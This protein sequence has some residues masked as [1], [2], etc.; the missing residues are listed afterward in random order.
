MG[1]LA[2]MS[3]PTTNTKRRTVHCSKHAFAPIASFRPKNA[4]A[5]SAA[6]PAQ[7]HQSNLGRAGLASES[8]FTGDDPVN[9]IDP[10]GLDCGL[11]SCACSAYDSAAGGVKTAAKDTGHAINAALPAIHTIANSVAIAASLCAVIT[12]ETVVGGVTC[13]A[14]ASVAGGVTAVTGGVLYLEGRESGVNAAFDLAGG[15]LGGTSSLYEAVADS[16]RALQESAELGSA[17][18]LAALRAS[19]WGAFAT[20]LSGI[21]RGLSA[22]AFGLGLGA[23]FGVNC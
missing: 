12:S 5:P 8:P 18:R 10:N 17:S 13:G 21:S 11:F 9:A 15:A 3:A 22:A 6:L 7:R 4:V 16:A 14:I 2:T 20:G 19:M 1:N 23:E